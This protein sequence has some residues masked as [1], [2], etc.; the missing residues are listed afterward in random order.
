MQSLTDENLRIG[1][2][3]DPADEDLSDG[4]SISVYRTSEDENIVKQG[5]KSQYQLKIDFVYNIA[6]YSRV[7]EA[8]CSEYSSMFLD[9]L[10]PGIDIHVEDYDGSDYVMWINNIKDEIVYKEDTNFWMETLT[11]SGFTYAKYI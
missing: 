3:R 11:V 8:H 5:F 2:L 4:L 7:S 6:I 9:F 1:D 10:K